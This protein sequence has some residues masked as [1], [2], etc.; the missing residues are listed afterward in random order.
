MNTDQ[1]IRAWAGDPSVVRAHAT[2]RPDGTSV[3]MSATELRARCQTVLQ[4]V[5]ADMFSRN[6]I[7]RALN[8]QRRTIS[9]G[10]SA[11]ETLR[12]H[13]R[14]VVAVT[15]GA[16]K[17]PLKPF[18]DELDYIN[19]HWERYGES[20]DAS[21]DN[22]AVGFYVFFSDANRKWQLTFVPGIA[23]ATA[24]E[25]WYIKGISPPFLLDRIPSEFHFGV[26]VG[27]LSYLVGG[28][29]DA[30]YEAVLARISNRLDP[31]KS[32]V[33]RIRPDDNLLKRNRARNANLSNQ[34]G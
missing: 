14:E 29:H 20:D 8:R 31:V 11:T 6:G 15:V 9:S 28:A 32:G 13:E 18:L 5:L 27:G 4:L 16:A 34:V 33:S 30:K 12:T 21:T 23:S 25:I 7:R 2:H 26:F 1:I 10:L 19:W 17:R 3:P 22:A 24:A